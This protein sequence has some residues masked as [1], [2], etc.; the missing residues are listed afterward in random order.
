M[1]EKIRSPLNYGNI[2]YHS[3]Q[4]TSR[5]CLLSKTVEIL[6]LGLELSLFLWTESTLRVSEYNGEI[7]GIFGLKKDEVTGGWKKLRNGKLHDIYS[8]VIII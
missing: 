4:K 1:D 8:S 7:R 2:R 5:T 6:T 3:T